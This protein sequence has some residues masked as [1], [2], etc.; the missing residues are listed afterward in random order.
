MCR[1]HET[2][3]LREASRY[4]CYTFWLPMAALQFFYRLF[5]PKYILA[6]TQQVQDAFFTPSTPKS[7]VEDLQRQLSPYESM[8]WPLQALNAFVTGPDVLQRIT[9]W[10]YVHRSLNQGT[11]STLPASGVTPRLFVLAAQ[12]DVLCRPATLL[13]TAR[14][15]RNAFR[16]CLEMRKWQGVSSET[17]ALADDDSRDGVRFKVVK[18]VAHHLQNHVEWERGSEEL[19]KWTELL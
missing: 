9:G 5:H 2:G 14:H 19:L 6:T 8:C 13:N 1:C 4:S 10:S 12:H 3:W 18:G 17:L 7:V 11:T 15:Y 16:Q